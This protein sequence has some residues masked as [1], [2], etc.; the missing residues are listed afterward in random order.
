V[1]DHL[2]R[3]VILALI[4]LV[5]FGLLYGFAG[6]GV[7]ALLFHDQASGSLSA[8]GSSLIGQNWNGYST[9]AIKNPQWFHGRPD[10]DNPLVANGTSGGSGASNLGPRSKTLVND[11]KALV[12]AWNAVGVTPTPDLV[13]GSGSGIDPDIT[14]QD[15]IVQIP[16]VSTATGI[17]ASQLRSLI[18]QHT[19][20]AQLGFLGAPTVN[21]LELNQALAALE[22][23]QGGQ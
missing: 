17:D 10:P 18:D 15:A 6:T 2:R 11:T 8:S 22:A 9:T 4:A 3:S 14:P 19:Q 12:Q 7:A 20:G 23:K 5:L 1:I 21:V 16:M 13:T